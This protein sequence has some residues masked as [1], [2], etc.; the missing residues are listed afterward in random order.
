MMQLKQKSSTL[1]SALL[2]LAISGSFINNSVFIVR[3]TKDKMTWD[4][5]EILPSIPSEF[6]TPHCRLKY[7]DGEKHI[8]DVLSGNPVKLVRAFFVRSLALE[9]LKLVL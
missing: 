7:L 6:S 8:D 9:I 2:E 3:P 5:E 1:R 4:G